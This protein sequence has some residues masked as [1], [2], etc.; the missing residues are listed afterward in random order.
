MSAGQPREHR[1][2]GR[3]DVG[4]LLDG[5]ARWPGRDGPVPGLHQG[6]L[7]WHL[8]LPD[9]EIAEAFHGWW[10][11]DDLLAVALVEGPVAR[12]EVGPD[13]GQDRDLAT[14]L[15]EVGRT[16]TGDTVYVDVAPDTALRRLLADDGWTPDPDPWVAL[17]ADLA[18]WSPTVALD[19]LRVADAADAVA[20]RVAVQR[21]GFERSTFTEDAWHRMADGPGYRRELDLVVST[22]DGAPASVATSWFVAPGA[23]AILEPVA[24]HRDHRGQGYGVRVVS[25]V[26][27]RLRRLG[28]S[29]VT[30]CTPLDYAG[31][32][33]TYRAA[34][35][36][37]VGELR[38]M[39]LDRAAQSSA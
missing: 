14:A 24:T 19:G 8:R 3:L 28:A 30:V 29:G 17:H 38:S 31:A 2:H 22:P 11:G 34:G 27:D 39:Q 21:A 20:D 12:V 5:M 23:T 33:A 16:M 4:R 35:F 7:G 13:H 26:V 1:I 9:D 36:A 15:A 10:H 18:T 25:A 6:D 32:V 37:T